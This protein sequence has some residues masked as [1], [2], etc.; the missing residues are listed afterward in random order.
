MINLLVLD[1]D[2]NFGNCIEVI[3]KQ[4]KKQIPA[5]LY[6][7]QVSHSE[8]L[9]EKIEHDH[10]DILVIENYYFEKLKFD[11]RLRQINDIIV[12][13]LSIYGSETNDESM[14]A[15]AK[16]L[17]ISRLISTLVEAEDRI[18]HKKQAAV[19][20]EKMKFIDTYI[21]EHLSEKLDLVT[22]SDT[23]HYSPS[24]LSKTFKEYFNQNIADYI[25]ELRMER[26]KTLLLTTNDQIQEVAEKI[27]IEKPN[28]FRQA[29]KRATGMSPS[30]FR[31]ER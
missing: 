17:N 1:S 22:L 2:I 25:M 29:F 24:Y 28:S 10:I 30:H 18:R 11:P 21:R 26:A 9:F 15:L 4:E 23:I 8:D 16:P 5:I 13:E 27:G 6:L 7:G 12:S 31:R 14:P 3:L 20:S 19:S